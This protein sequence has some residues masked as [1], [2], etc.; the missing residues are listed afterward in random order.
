MIGCAL[1]SGSVA[2]AATDK[3]GAAKELDAI[4]HRIRGLEKDIRK[5]ASARPTAGKAL[6]QAE[7]AESEA[8]RAL[9][10]VRGELARGRVREREL[11]AELTRAEAELAGHRQS[12]ERQVRLAYVAGRE[13]WLRLAL[14]EGDPLALSRKVAYYGYI[15][16]QRGELLQQVEA[17]VSALET[18]TAAL[19]EQLTALDELVRRR[20]ARVREVTAARVVRAEAVKTL[21]R[22]LDTRQAKLGRLRNEAR[23]L[24]RLM[25][26][27]ARE[28]SRKPARQPSA[29]PDTAPPQQVRDLPLAGR[30]VARYGQPR[31]DGLLR[32][33][34][35]MLAAPAGTSVRSV[36]PGRV[37]YA[38]WLPGLG[39]LVVVDHGRGLMSLYG[40]NQEVLKK[41]GDTVR[42]GEVIARV[43]DSGGQ[44]SPG[45]YFEVRRN[46]KP[47]NPQAWVR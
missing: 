16:R 38:D 1:V 11:R 25:A 10:D 35:V 32:W 28:S 27:L 18:T 20:E 33:D 24:E 45:L 17:E 47:V 22:D 34:G 7:V 31:A 46:G 14:A 21:K 26:R 4:E 39:Q 37:V 13:E 9:D 43:G 6:R 42:Q 40:H 2:F 44:G 19:G 29:V 41:V 30:M 8:R 5:A 23:A 12:V 3:A 15:T 36:Q